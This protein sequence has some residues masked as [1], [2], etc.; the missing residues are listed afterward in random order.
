MQD[1]PCVRSA[2]TTDIE[3]EMDRKQ[4]NLAFVVLG[5]VML[6]AVLWIGTFL[7]IT[8][9]QPSTSTVASRPMP[10]VPTL[11]PSPVVDPSIKSGQAAAAVRKKLLALEGSAQVFSDIRAGDVNG[12]LRIT[13]TNSWFDLKPYQKRQTTQTIATLWQ[14]ELGEGPAILHIYDLTGREIAGTRTFGGVWIEEK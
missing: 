1:S 14:R 4:T 6:M 11:S 9:Q 3:P 7:F 12:V 13:V 5:T 8:T 2:G 10:A